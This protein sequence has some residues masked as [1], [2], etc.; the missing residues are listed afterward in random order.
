MLAR[1]PSQMEFV[2]ERVVLKSIEDWVW[3]CEGGK[4]GDGTGNSNSL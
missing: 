4:H 3:M 2:G 1:I